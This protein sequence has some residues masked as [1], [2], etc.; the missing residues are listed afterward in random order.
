MSDPDTSPE[1][2][3]AGLDQDGHGARSPGFGVRPWR[4][5][6]PLADDDS[7]LPQFLVGP[8][9]GF[10]P[11][12]DPLA[13]LPGR[14]AALDDLLRRMTIRR[15]DG[16][17]GLLAAGA[18]GDAVDRDLPL[19]EVDDIA[20]GRQLAALYRD[21]TF[22]A[23]AYLLEPCDLHWRRDRQYGLGRDRLPRQM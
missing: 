11:R 18:F 20:D 19:I 4:P 1:L 12:Q 3:P 10:L 17:A 22:A 2:H 5:T 23:S 14:F 7:L 13:V 9:N 15:R 16:S 6:A 8:E 21:Y